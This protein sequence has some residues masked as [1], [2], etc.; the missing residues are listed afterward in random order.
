MLTRFFHITILL[1]SFL[2]TLFF[3]PFNP[4]SCLCISF[5]RFCCSPPS[6]FSVMARH[7]D[8]EETELFQKSQRSQN[9][10]N[11]T[12]TEKGLIGLL[13]ISMLTFLGLIGLLIAILLNNANQPSEPP[14]PTLNP[15]DPTLPPQLA[16]KVTKVIQAKIEKENADFLQRFPRDHRYVSQKKLAFFPQPLELTRMSDVPDDEDKVTE[17]FNSVDENNDGSTDPWELHDWM[18]YVESH[19]HKHILD[20]QWHSLGQAENDNLTWPDYVFKVRHFSGD[21]FCAFI[22][23]H[24]CLFSSTIPWVCWLIKWNESWNATDVDGS[25]RI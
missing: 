20:Q 7:Q 23:W 16:R 24:F 5:V 25:T 14:T 19:V 4:H 12:A 10:R 1:P 13:I 6:N 21:I 11:R 15:L 8:D 17:I 2:F 3:A 9:S 18:L 22:G